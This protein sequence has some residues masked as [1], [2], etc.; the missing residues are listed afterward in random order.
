MLGP[1]KL[2]SC[3][4]TNNY[5]CE[6]GDGYAGGGICIT[7]AGAVVR[8]CLIA[9][10]NARDDN[11]NGGGIAMTAGLVE[12]CVIRDNVAYGNYGGV[13]QMGGT[14]RNCL[15]SGNWAPRTTN[16][17]VGVTA[18]SAQFINNTVVTN[19]C[20]AQAS[21][22]AAN[23]AAGTVKN[24][25]FWGSI[26]TDVNQG[27]ATVSYCQIGGDPAF[28]NPAKGDWRLLPTSPCI[29]AGDWTALEESREAVRA[30][31]DLSGASRLF[32]GQ[33]DLGCYESRV[34]GTMILLR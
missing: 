23:L 4:V 2:I 10:N 24:L 6:S 15:I 31:S 18:A 21:G 13:Y 3:V 12:N 17:G 22:K 20:A 34:A 16:Q 9:H 19:G 7:D 30:M 8:D 25:I 11:R 29:N 5:A 28:K 33:V 26:G 27:G 32:G 14:V 1:G